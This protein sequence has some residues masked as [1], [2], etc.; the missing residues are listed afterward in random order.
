[1]GNKI[2]FVIAGRMDD[3]KVL[4]GPSCHEAATK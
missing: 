4:L 3:V 2:G 1:M